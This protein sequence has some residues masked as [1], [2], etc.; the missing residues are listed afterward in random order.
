MLVP[1]HGSKSSSSLAFI[2][3]VAPKL[4][5]VTSGY[6][7]RFHHPHEEVITR[8]TGQGVRVVDTVDAGAMTLYFPAD[9][10]TFTQSGWRLSHPHWW[11]R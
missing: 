3:A 8:Y 10:T 2:R 7:N 4:A 1:H 9:E 11:S 5:I 6:R